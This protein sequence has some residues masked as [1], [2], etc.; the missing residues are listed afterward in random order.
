MFLRGRGVH[1]V[2]P[3]FGRLGALLQQP[4][5]EVVN[6]LATSFDHDSDQA[7]FLRTMVNETVD[8]DWETP[9]LRDT[10]LRHHD[11]QFLFRGHDCHPQIQESLRTIADSMSMDPSAV[12]VVAAAGDKTAQRWLAST[13]VERPATVWPEVYEA[14]RY[15]YA[16]GP[17]ADDW[18]NNHVKTEG[19]DSSVRFV[20]VADSW[21]EAHIVAAG[22]GAKSMMFENRMSGVVKGAEGFVPDPNSND[23][24]EFPAPFAA[25]RRAIMLGVVEAS[26]RSAATIAAAMH[27]AAQSSSNP[28]AA[29]R[30]AGVDAMRRTSW[31][32]HPSMV[33]A[34]MH[35]SPD[36]KFGEHERVAA[37]DICRTEHDLG[38]NRRTVN[39]EAIAPDMPWSVPTIL[40]HR[41]GGLT[42]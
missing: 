35:L 17:P 4:P 31:P 27:D 25:I 40:P 9:E 41:G 1:E 7:K 28:S 32:I 22:A 3:C 30:E 19:P 6:R 24:K 21:E 14:V 33:A 10:Y 2:A 23:V 12:A 13:V 11:T 38:R 36:S 37:I 18:H 39:I 34:A 20:G 5:A 26:L 8:D 29:A 16:D 42:R 15:D